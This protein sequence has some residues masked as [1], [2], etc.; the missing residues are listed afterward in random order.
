MYLLLVILL[1][2]GQLLSGIQGNDKILNKIVVMT[3]GPTGVGKSSLLNAL[4]CPKFLYY[5]EE[6]C[7]FVTGS[8]TNSVTKNINWVAGKWLGEEGDGDVNL[9]AYDTPGLG[10]TYGKDPQ[11]LK[12]IAETIEASERGNFNALLLVFKAQHRFNQSIQKQLR[13]LE[14]IY[15]PNIWK[16]FVL[17]FT[18]YGFSDDKMNTRQRNCRKEKKSEY[19]NKTERKRFCEEFDYE[20]DILGKWQQALKDF[21]GDTNLTI[22]GVFVD[23]H[24][25]WDNEQE[26]NMFF[27]QTETLFQAIT[28]RSYV[29]CDSSCLERMKLSVRAESLAPEILHDENVEIEQG[30]TLNLECNLFYGF[31]NSLSQKS[32]LNWLHNG[33][34]IQNLPPDIKVERVDRTGT[35]KKAWLTKPNATMT[36]SGSYRCR[37]GFSSDDPISQPTKVKLY[38]VFVGD[39]HN[40][41]SRQEFDDMIPSEQITWF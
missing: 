11:T 9:V 23:S 28:S 2:H 20:K 27:N 29:S 32:Q 25:N 18:F 5:E 4:L 24:L 19:P 31:E 30:S 8:G 41:R 36:D 22:P 35:V 34:T 10:D 33:S 16:S 14:Y 6:D 3:I 37:F 12:A 1:I 38:Q 7:H 39:K 13:I 21:H 26:T 15:G 40:R 17:A